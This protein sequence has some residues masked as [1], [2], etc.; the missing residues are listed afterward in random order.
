[1]AAQRIDA[2]LQD[3][4]AR[5]ARAGAITVEPAESAEEPN[6][7][8]AWHYTHPL[9]SPLV[10]PHRDWQAV[11]AKAHPGLNLRCQF[12]GDW[13]LAVQKL[14]VS[15]AAGE[16]PDIALV[17]RAW[18]APLIRSGRLAPLNTLVPPKFLDEFSPAVLA[19]LS[20]DNQLYALPADGFCSVLYYDRNRV[21]PPPATWDALRET[22]RGLS[23]GAAGLHAIGHVPFIESLWSAGGRVCDSVGSGLDARPASE[24]LDFVLSLCREGLAHPRALGDPE[25][26]F[27]LFLRGDVAMTVASSDHLPRTRD[28]AFPIGVAPVPGRRGGVSKL[29][30]HALVVFAK[31]AYGKRAAIA[32]ALD[33]LTGADVQAQ[34]PALGSAF[35]R[36]GLAPDLDTQPGL[37]RAYACARNTPLVTSWGAVESELR[38]YLR[39]AY[40]WQPG[41]GANSP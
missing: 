17:Q 29:S 25:M 5:D 32:S 2:I 13:S 19:T 27:A 39:L 28:A 10:M 20:V 33:F 37:A 12:I 36:P 35:T 6:T 9:L 15:L 30:D 16:L 24:A 4:R 8:T 18:L 7:V 14:T 41:Q 11:V 22:A 3:E 1:M 31:H 23:G 26:G 38:R 21:F 40:R 34:C